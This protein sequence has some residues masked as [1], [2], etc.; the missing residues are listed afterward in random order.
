M[1]NILIAVL[2]LLFLA[3]SSIIYCQP[4]RSPHPELENPAIQNINKEAPHSTF[5][6]YSN[7]NEAIADIKENSQNFLSLNGIWGFNFALGFQNRIINYFENKLDISKWNKIEVP[8]NMEIKGYGI[9]HYLN[10][11][12]EWAADRSQK[13]PY[14]DMDNNSFGYY[15]KEF[16]LPTNW[17]GKE[18]FIHFGAIK[19]AGYIYVNGK[20]VGLTKDSKTPAEFNITK[21]LVNG[22]NLIAL[23]VIRWSDGSYLECQDYWR[24]SGIP[25]EVYL[26]SQP[27][28]RIKDFFVKAILDDE[29]TAGIFNLDIELKNHI[30]KIVEANITI[31][32]IDSDS[33]IIFTETKSTDKFNNEK[34]AIISFDHKISN[35]KQWSAESPNLY[36]LLIYTKDENNSILELT[37]TQIGFRKVEIRDG[38]LLVN[39]KRILIKGVNLHEFN[40]LTGQVVDRALMLKD[41]EQMKKLNINAVR[42]SHYPQPE[43][44]YKLC[45]KYGIYLVAEANIESHG[46]GYNL[47]VGGTLGNNPAWLNAHLTRTKNSVERDKNHP[48]VIIWSLGNEAGNGYN[49]YNTYNWIKQ[50]D[51][52]RPVQYERALFEWNTDIY[53]PMYDQIWDME[54]YAINNH[55]RP[56][57][58]CEYAHAMGNSIGNLK[59]YWETIEKY[60]NLQGGFIWDWADQGLLKKDSS[61]EYWAY[62]GDYGPNGTPSDGNFLIN[63]VVFPDRS[64]KPHSMEVKK[65]YQNIAFTPVDLNEGLIEISNK[66]RFTNLEKYQF[67]W[68]ILENGKI[69]KVGSIDTMNIEPEEKGKIKID[70]GKLSFTSGKEYFLNLSAKLKSEEPPLPKGWEIAYEQIQFPCIERKHDIILPTKNMITITDKDNIEFRGENFSIEFNKLSG[71]MTSYN[72]NGNELIKDHKGLRPTFWRAPTDND[73]GWNMPRKCAEYKNASENDLFADKITYNKNQDG[74]IILIVDYNFQII[75]TIWK[76][77]Y[78]IYENGVI[79]LENEIEIDDPSNVIV[80]RIGMKMLL[81][82]EYDNLEFFGR[83]PW[84][85]YWDRKTAS[86]LGIYSSSVG[87]QYTPYI[88]PQE[89]GHK[90]DVRW[91]SLLNKDDHGLMIVADSLIEFNALN[92]LVEDFDAGPDKDLNLKHTTD[93]KKRDLIELHVDHKMTGVG[94][95]D[96]WGATPHKEYSLFSEKSEYKINFYI[97]VK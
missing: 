52:T 74:T 77:N 54:K 82:A 42:T 89:N 5:F 48:S 21:Y 59:D 67:D 4:K 7:R 38:T 65:V 34:N 62:G 37:S 84:E 94:G 61:G 8:S 35:V 26:Y 14:V 20:Y 55:D 36:T 24:I 85:N 13:P 93:I 49:F 70:F 73:Y 27:Q 78:T 41:I 46:M 92:N 97:L 63:G 39:G 79:Y 25:R 30:E 12:Y 28:T 91:L 86:T 69:I 11:P 53:C 31:E 40:P 32:L 71:I 66:F 72:Y 1:K 60:P 3:L 6:T 9:P 15:R 83:G 90:S 64:F 17:K 58:L 16:E 51:N 76:A 57:I 10:H 87:E 88:R 47:K 19:S 75:K 44:W 29:Y 95:D 68:S 80:P 43:E 23:E 22:K 33:S 45:D 18:I 96:S 2:S 81:P 50:R 56:L